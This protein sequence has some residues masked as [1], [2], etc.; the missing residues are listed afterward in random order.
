MTDATKNIIRSACAMDATVDLKTVD[1]AISLLDGGAAAE[2][3]ADEI[4]TPGE[5]AKM[6]RCTTR[7]VMRYG[8][9]GHIRRIGNRKE[10]AQTRYSKRSVL[11]FLEGRAA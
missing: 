8:K 3:Q 10:G 1:A 2:P 4:L 11:A 6:L 5:V 9:L 7:T